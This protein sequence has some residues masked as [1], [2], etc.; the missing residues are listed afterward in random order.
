[1]QCTFEIDLKEPNASDMLFPP[2]VKFRLI[3]LNMTP[4]CLTD[5]EIDFQADKLLKQVEKLRKE[6]KKKLRAARS[7]HDKIIEGKRKK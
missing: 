6:V 4:N 1:M 3:Q 5:A 7:R 2:Y